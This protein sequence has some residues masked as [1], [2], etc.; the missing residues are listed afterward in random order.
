MRMEGRGRISSS[1]LPAGAHAELR[2]LKPSG[3]DQTSEITMLR[4]RYRVP[5]IE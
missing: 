2:K 3:I 1:V 4:D 5:R